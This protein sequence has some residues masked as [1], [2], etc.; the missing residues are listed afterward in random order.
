[1][2]LEQSVTWGFEDLT[3]TRP[4]SDELL[5]AEDTEEA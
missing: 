4:S 5:A 1:M 2:T 3:S